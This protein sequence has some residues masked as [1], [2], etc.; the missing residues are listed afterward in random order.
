V[1][2]SSE[3]RERFMRMD[4]ELKDVSQGSYE[5]VRRPDIHRTFP[6]AGS[7]AEG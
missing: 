5:F 6:I 7:F 4:C 3:G 1:T 2:C